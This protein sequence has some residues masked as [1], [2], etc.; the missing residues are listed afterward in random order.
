MGSAKLGIDQSP[1][2][3]ARTGFHPGDCQVG[4]KVGL[5]VF[6]AFL[7]R[8]CGELGPWIRLLAPD[9]LMGCFFG[10]MSCHGHVGAGVATCRHVF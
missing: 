6:A 4:P 7:A 3:S 1:S 9:W 5:G 8:F 10:S 2:S